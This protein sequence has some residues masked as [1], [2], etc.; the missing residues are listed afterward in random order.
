MG[1]SLNRLQKVLEFRQGI[2]FSWPSSTE[3]KYKLSREKKSV[4]GGGRQ[5][6]KPATDDSGSE[7][8]RK[9][10]SPSDRDKFRK[11]NAVYKIRANQ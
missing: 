8:R 4:S 11:R 2:W 5:P 3:V 6:T 1:K 9:S 7:L 10:T